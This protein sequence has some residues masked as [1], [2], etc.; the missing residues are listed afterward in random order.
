MTQVTHLS[1][2]P[3]I[4]PEGEKTNQLNDKK[5]KELIAGRTLTIQFLRVCK[6]NILLFLEGLINRVDDYLLN[7]R[8]RR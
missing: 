5:D 2:S 1:I 3:R 7:K 8:Y 6:N 4:L